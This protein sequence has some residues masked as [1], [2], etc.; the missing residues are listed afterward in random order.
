MNNE[1]MNSALLNSSSVNGRFAEGNNQYNM[2]Q[3]I[4]GFSPFSPD[5]NYLANLVGNRELG[6]SAEGMST[7][8]SSISKRGSE[9]LPSGSERLSTAAAV[10]LGGVGR[11]ATPSQVQQPQESHDFGSARAGGRYSMDRAPLRSFMEASL[12]RPSSLQTAATSHKES[13]A[14]HD[15]LADLNGTLASLDLDASVG[16][17]SARSPGQSTDSGKSVQFRMN[18]NSPTSPA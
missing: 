16:S 10:G 18:M 11:S 13:Q 12:I 1:I 3:A 7:I 4:S 2:H 5:P 14:E 9:V 6:I 8:Q 15:P 17:G